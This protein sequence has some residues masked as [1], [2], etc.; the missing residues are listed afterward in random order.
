MGGRRGTGRSREGSFRRQ[1][2]Y[3]LE[4]TLLV[5]SHERL[6]SLRSLLFTNGRGGLQRVSSPLRG[7]TFHK[8]LD[9]LHSLLFTLETGGSSPDFSDAQYQGALSMSSTND[10]TSTVPLLFLTIATSLIMEHRSSSATGTW[11]V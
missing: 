9:S 7:A 1:V 5:E 3:A 6:D 8:R 4:P 11:S 2:R 10:S